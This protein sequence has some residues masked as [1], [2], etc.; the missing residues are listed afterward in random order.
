MHIVESTSA[1][2]DGAVQSADAASAVFRRLSAEDR[3]AFLEKIAAE[4]EGLGDALI[5]RGSG[6]TALPVARI[7]GERGRTT[8]QLR[9]FAALVREGSWC[10][11]RIDRALPDRK[12]AP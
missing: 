1:E 3:A 8:G 5:E 2:I 6:E 7:T 11:A 12:P 10:D 4:I 9:L